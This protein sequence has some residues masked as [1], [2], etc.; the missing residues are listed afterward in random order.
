MANQRRSQIGPVIPGLQ[1]QHLY[2]GAYAR[3]IGIQTTQI[4]PEYLAALNAKFGCHLRCKAGL[5]TKEFQIFAIQE[6]NHGPV[7]FDREFV[8]P[9]GGQGQT[10]A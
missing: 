10:G 2:G 3:K 8:D 1:H 9:F 5:G 7:A 4:F 6:P